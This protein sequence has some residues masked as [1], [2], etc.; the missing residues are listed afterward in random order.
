VTVKFVK[1][2]PFTVC[3]S[4]FLSKLSDIRTLPQCK[5]LDKFVVNNNIENI[6]KLIVNDQYCS[7]EELKSKITRVREYA[8]QYLYLAV[9]KFYIY[10]TVDTYPESIKI[11]YDYKLIEFCD[12]LL[13]DQYVLVNYNTEPDDCGTLGNFVH[14]VTTMFFKRYA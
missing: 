11:D 7:L 13:S 4:V 6:F 1:S 8:H 2:V 5:E 10:S 12:N 14:P 3:K 9:N